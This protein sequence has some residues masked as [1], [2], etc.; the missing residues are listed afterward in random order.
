M[1]RL[2][3]TSNEPK[4]QKKIVSVSKFTKSYAL[5]NAY[6]IEIA[7]NSNIEKKNS[8]LSFPYLSLLSLNVEREEKKIG[9]H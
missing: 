9:K 8:H 2:K 7:L 5:N 4:P 3:T 6:T 1:A